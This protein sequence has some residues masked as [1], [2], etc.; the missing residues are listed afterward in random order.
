MSENKAFRHFDLP[1]D[2]LSR[3]VHY[4][5]PKARDAEEIER[6]QSL[7]SG[8]LLA[9]M[10]ERGT[11]VAAKLIDFINDQEDES[12]FAP[13]TIAAAGLNTAW[14]NHAQG[15][16]DVMRRRLWLPVHY[17]VPDEE[18]PISR[19]EL[20]YTGS[21]QLQEGR[22]LAG[23]LMESVKARN[24]AIWSF[25]KKYA[26]KVGNASLV[27]ASVQV[28]DNVR[29]SMDQ[30]EQQWHARRGAMQALNASRNLYVAT[31]ANPTLA[32]LADKDSPLS[33]HI[34]REGSNLSVDGLESAHADVLE[35][36]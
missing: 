36:A 26:R 7:P 34:R 17:R 35:A 14:Y 16:Q 8:V 15:A 6:R 28:V 20:L 2:H 21:E 12:D 32:Q 19:E 18:D 1:V 29:G 27:L 24:S 3:E 4:V 22:V 9:K 31:G 25:K 5:P 30:Y 23:F 11:A 33:V 13:N 10:Q